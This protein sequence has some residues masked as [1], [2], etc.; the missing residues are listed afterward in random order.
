MLTGILLL[1][2]TPR[3]FVHSVF[4]LL[5]TSSS[6]VP[7]KTAVYYFDFLLALFPL[8]KKLLSIIIQSLDDR[9]LHTKDFAEW[10][11]ADLPL[12]GPWAT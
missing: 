2:I 12:C 3:Q 6:V 10:N 5:V 11:V 7:T 8:P 4:I 9:H 1:Q